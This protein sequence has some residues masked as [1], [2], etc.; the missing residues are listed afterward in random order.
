MR[1]FIKKLI[2]HTI[3]QKSEPLGHLLEA[4]F[5][6]VL[7]G[8][9]ARKLKVIGITGTDGKTTTCTLTAQ[10][11]RNSG[12][13]VAMLTTISLDLGD[14]MG[15][16]AN[17]TRLTTMGSRQ[18]VRNLKQIKNAGAEWLV[19]EVTSHALAQNRVWGIPFSVVAMT[20]LNH[21][22]LDYHGTFERYRDAKAKL[23][24]LAA[25]NHRGLQV[26]I[27]NADDPSSTYFAERVPN[28]TM[29][30][31]NKGDLIAKDINQSSA[32]SSYTVEVDDTI[33]VITCNLPGGF[34]VYNSLAVLGIGRAVGLTP[35]EIEEG[36][37]SLHSVEG[38]MAR[39]DEGQDFEVIIDYAHT[40]ESFEKIF[41][42]VKPT[43]KGKLIVVFGSAGRRDAEKRTTQGELAGKYA[44]IVV[45]TEEDD[46]DIDGMAILKQIAAGSEAS[47]KKQ[48]KDLFL[49][50]KRED[51]VSEAVKRAK[52]GDVV[53]LL[54]KG[55][56][57]SIL[58]N[59]PGI[60]NTEA[61]NYDESTM[62]FSRP[63]SEEQAA[64]TALKSLK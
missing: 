46:R 50:H 14:G 40:P 57:K 28:K 47:G 11:L 59:K 15:S 55:H 48:G 17:K 20:N 8:F 10:M 51:A 33:Y 39:I 36:I 37:A 16:R 53:L 9:P 35:K 18:L 43:V 13:K 58:G 38:R 2:P 56:E 25:K 6:Q 42:E 32:G 21:E 27:A 12:K 24:S 61:D 23:F 30:G 31:I 44:D 4:M 3:F 29:Y 22:H 5:W 62:T 63:Y 41:Q 1:S 54:G 19:L 34:N 64:R 60:L 45:V 26:G 7:A 49:V 52:K